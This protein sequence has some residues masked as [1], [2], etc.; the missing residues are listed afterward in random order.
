MPAPRNF[1]TSIGPGPSFKCNCPRFI[2][3]A[4]DLSSETLSGVLLNC[5]HMLASFA[6]GVGFVL[7]DGTNAEQD[8]ETGDDVGLFYIGADKKSLLLTLENEHLPGLLVI[9][10]RLCVADDTDYMP[11][12]MSFKNWSDDPLNGIPPVTCGYAT[13]DTSRLELAKM[14]AP[15]LAMY[16]RQTACTSCGSVTIFNHNLLGLLYLGMVLQRTGKCVACLREE[17]LLPSF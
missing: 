17:S 10:V 1:T 5:A 12:A 7:P 8:L 2:H 15:Y 13:K 16:A 4:N 6:Q 11:V 9:P 3:W 14:A